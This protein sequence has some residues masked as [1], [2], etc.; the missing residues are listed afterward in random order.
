MC[1]NTLIM[2]TR[3]YMYIYI[4]SSHTSTFQLLD[5]PWSQVDALHPP[6]SFLHFLSRIGSRAQINEELDKSNFDFIL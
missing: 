3:Y 5:K 4:S 6:G 1:H 2:S